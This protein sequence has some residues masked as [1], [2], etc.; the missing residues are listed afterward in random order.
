MLDHDANYAGTHLA[1]ALVAEHKGDNAKALEEYRLAEKLW[2]DADAN[3]IEL[4]QVKTK[5]AVLNNKTQ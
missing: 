1:L 5:I 4:S 2:G 3:L